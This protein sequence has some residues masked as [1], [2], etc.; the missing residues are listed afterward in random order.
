MRRVI[1]F[2]LAKRTKNDLV[3]MFD[4]RS[5][6]CRRVIEEFEERFAASGAHAGIA[7][8]LF[9]YA[10]RQEGRSACSR[11]AVKLHD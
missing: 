4:G 5:K 6:A 1:E 11:E 2:I 3:L 8:V 10:A 9:V 7:C